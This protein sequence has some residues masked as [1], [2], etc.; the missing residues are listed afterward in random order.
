MT[1]SV[2]RWL[3]YV[4][5]LSAAAS[6]W[7]SRP[8]AG[9]YPA[10][11]PHGQL[12]RKT[13]APGQVAAFRSTIQHIV[14]ILKENHSFDSLFGTF[15]GADG[16]TSGKISTGERIV[17]RRTPDLMPRDIGHEW[18]DARMAIDNGKMD[19]FDLLGSANV[20]G[21]YLS[22]SQYLM[23]DIPNYW[24]YA[25]HFMLADRMFS[26]LAGPS[27]PSHL[28]AIAGQSGGAI[29]VPTHT[30]PGPLLNWGCDADSTSTVNVLD[31][32]GNLT[33]PFP[34]FDFPTLGDALEAAGVSWGYYAPP[35]GYIGYIW[36]AFSAISH[37]RFG[38]LWDQR[39]PDWGQFITDATNGSLPSVSWLIPDLPVSD[40][41]MSQRGMCAGEN[42]TVEQI[43]AVMQGPAWPT[44][45]IVLMW[46]DF[47]GFYDHVT[48]P[49]ADQFGFGP[50]VPLIVISPYVKEGVVS[51]TIYETSSVLQ[52]IEALYNLSPLTNR[53]AQA[54]SLLDMFDFS[55]SP[56]P[57]L[58]LP[59]RTCPS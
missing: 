17:L 58:I 10:S 25:E 28:Y 30:A 37:I 4:V 56:A 24:S 7:A 22:M 45:V 39:V 41:P 32:S 38:P 42:W 59:P 35:Q 47:G 11:I 46:D 20:D 52:L 13:P 9:S 19:Q 1:K 57:P 27:F 40:H 15:P 18:V 34:C 3:T 55:Q 31:A 48:P 29:D 49:W 53:D 43:N 8:M 21:D 6:F 5:L 12:V 36:S 33:T 51:H 50:R 16:A 54:N 44:T 26:P 14:F 23:A 2:L